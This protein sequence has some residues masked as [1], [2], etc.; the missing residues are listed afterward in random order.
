[1]KDEI[2]TVN[3][4]KYKCTSCASS[5]FRKIKTKLNSWGL[6]F[7]DIEMFAKSGEALICK[8]CGLKHEF[9]KEFVK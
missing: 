4:R 9:Y 7:F 6:T 2:Q 1:M 8:N 5:D 3:G